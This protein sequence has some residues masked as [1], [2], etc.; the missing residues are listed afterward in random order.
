MRRLRKWWIGRRREAVDVEH[1]TTLYVDMGRWGWR[2]RCSA[3][4]TIPQ[5]HPLAPELA[6][7]AEATDHELEVSAG[8]RLSRHEHFDPAIWAGMEGQP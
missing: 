7:N 4:R 3:G 5:D 8:P 1:Y 2:C 6:A